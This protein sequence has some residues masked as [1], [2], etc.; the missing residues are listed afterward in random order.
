MKNLLESDF[1]VVGSGIAGLSFAVRASELGSVTLITKKQDTESNTNYAQ[2]GIACVLGEDDDFSLHIQDTLTSG[3]GLCHPEVVEIVVR[4]GPELVQELMQWG[5]EFTRKVDGS[6]KLDLGKEGGHSRRRIVHAKD[7]TGQEVEQALLGKVRSLR[8]VKVFEHQVAIDLLFTGSQADRRCVGVRAIDSISNEFRI[9]TAG[10]VLLATGGVGRVY[11]HTT[12]P[13]IA[14]G[15]G[16]VMAYRAGARVANMEFIQ[17]HPTSLYQEEQV[18]RAFLISEAVR[19][20]GG[21]LRTLDGETFMEKYHPLGCL[22]PRDVVARAIDHE[23]KHRGHPYVLLE[24]SS[25]SP[26][27]IESHFP[28]IYSHCKSLN[29]D[30]ACEPIP[31]VPAAHYACGGIQTNLD[32]ESSIPGLFATGETSCTGLHGANRLASNSLLE[33]LVFSHRAFQRVARDLEKYR[34]VA[35]SEIN[36]DF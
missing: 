33:A 31:V 21:I 7:L 15:D 12:N 8:N 9:Y 26:D 1:I 19:G 24:L 14:T 22:A 4:E 3:A 16:V 18:P 5:V 34:L 17:F 36:L 29:L 20:E 28:N 30:I 27:F 10:M 2:G 25:M 11:L 6:S 35:A 13:L 32:G 23:M